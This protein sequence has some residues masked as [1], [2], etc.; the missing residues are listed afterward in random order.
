MSVLYQSGV[1]HGGKDSVDRVPV[2]LHF[3]VLMPLQAQHGVGPGNCG[4]FFL[5][6]PKLMEDGSLFLLPAPPAQHLLHTDLGDQYERSADA[7][8]A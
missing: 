5:A 1:G 3:I 7:E 6:V 8:N 2:G 4:V